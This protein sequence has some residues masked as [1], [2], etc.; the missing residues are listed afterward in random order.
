M[1]EDVPTTLYLDR[2][3]IDSPGSGVHGIVVSGQAD[4]NDW[5][6]RCY[7]APYPETLPRYAAPGAAE[8]GEY[9]QLT[10]EILHCRDLDR[11]GKISRRLAELRGDDPPPD[12]PHA[13]EGLGAS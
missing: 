7:S 2:L 3:K 1:R 10:Q 8:H 11:A 4:A 5:W 9:Q 6:Y 13:R 12:Y